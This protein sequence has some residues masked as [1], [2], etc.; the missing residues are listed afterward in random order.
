MEH[1]KS[2][3]QSMLMALGFSA[4]EADVYWTLLS[5]DTVSIRKVADHSGIN[6][7]TTYEAI[8]VLLSAGLVRARK[9]GNRDYYSAESPEKIYDIIREKRKNLWEVQQVA[10]RFIPEL[11]AKKARPQGKPLVRYFEDD[12]GIVA[13]LR[14]VL[15]VCGQLE[16]QEYYVYSSRTLRGYIYRKFPEFTE[17]RIKEGIRV[18]VIAVG[19]G[20]EPTAAAERK[21]LPEPSKADITSYVMIYGDKVAQI[22]ISDDHTPYGV[23]IEDAGSASMQKLLFEQLWS[24]L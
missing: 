13:I 1:D 21:W 14:D 19:E 3:V 12:E 11:L 24:T 2:T 8:K 20:G 10:K 4:K 23:V 22:S 5:L 15:Q 7:G 16:Q 17:K 18:K 9:S 6:R